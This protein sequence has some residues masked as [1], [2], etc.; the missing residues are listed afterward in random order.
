MRMV[1]RLIRPTD[2]ALIAEMSQFGVHLDM[3]ARRPSAIPAVLAERARGI[4]VE[5]AEH[6][7]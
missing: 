6:A 5:P 4:L 7:R 1:H 3:E 2:D